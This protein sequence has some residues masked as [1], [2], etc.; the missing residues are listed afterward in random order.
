[1]KSGFRVEMSADELSTVITACGVRLQELGAG[2]EK[3]AKMDDEKAAN[4]LCEKYNELRDVLR[5]LENAEY[6]LETG[7]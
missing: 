7:A 3:A 1:M 5:L 6:F 2:I 4:F